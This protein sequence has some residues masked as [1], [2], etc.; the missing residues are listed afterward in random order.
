MGFI[1]P[2]R[3]RDDIPND[4]LDKRDLAIKNLSELVRV[5]TSTQ[6]DGALN[7]MIGRG[8]RLVIGNQ[9]EVLRIDFPASQEGPARLFLSVPSGAESE[10]T[11]KLTG[12]EL[13]GCLDA[14]AKL[15]NNTRRE[16]NLSVFVGHSLS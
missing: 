12:G 7:V 16:R 6:D 1:I 4:L 5:E 9:A 10:V 11:S 2:S 8:Q 14:G 3:Q 13:G 15:I